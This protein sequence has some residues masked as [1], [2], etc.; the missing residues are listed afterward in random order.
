MEFMMSWVLI[1]G[2]VLVGVLRFRTHFKMRVD[3]HNKRFRM[4]KAEDYV[5]EFLVEAAFMSVF[6]PAFT[7]YRFIH[8]NFLQKMVDET[9]H[10]DKKLENNLW[11]R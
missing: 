2:Y 3:A 4:L 1:V 10:P 8:A 6:W 5:G 11:R 7:V 9:L